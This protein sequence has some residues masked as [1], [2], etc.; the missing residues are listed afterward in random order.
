MKNATAS[1]GLDT[2]WASNEEAIR[3]WGEHAYYQWDQPAGLA[4]ELLRA[5]VLA[6]KPNRALLDL[7]SA[8]NYQRAFWKGKMEELFERGGTWYFSKLARELDLNLE[9]VVELA[10]ELIKDGKVKIDA[11]A[12]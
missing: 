11:D 4:K 8:Q 12:R 5:R 10:R 9:L 6:F 1:G 7:H 3:W 2:E